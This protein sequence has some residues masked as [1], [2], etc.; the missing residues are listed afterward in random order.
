[1][2]LLGAF[3]DVS[4][5]ATALTNEASFSPKSKKKD[6]VGSQ[7]TYSGT[8]AASGVDPASESDLVGRARANEKTESGDQKIA[9]KEKKLRKDI[10]YET[11]NEDED[12]G[13]DCCF[14]CPMM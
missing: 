14:A 8:S 11:D 3:V 5:P 2:S 6:V 1:M 4:Q 13:N 12:N 9:T 10:A 7:F